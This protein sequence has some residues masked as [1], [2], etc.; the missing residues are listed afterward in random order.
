MQAGGGGAAPTGQGPRPP[1]AAS[2]DG[3][4]RPAGAGPGMGGG[5]RG[6]GIDE[7]VERFPDI[8][9]ADLKL[10]DTIAVVSSTKTADTVHIAAIKFL[11]GVEPFLKMA[12]MA[13]AAAGG[14][15]RGGQG[16][17]GSFTIPGLDGFGGP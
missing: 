7:M 14:Q 1:G 17:S 6:G 16:V 11:S 3:Q 12:Q 5:Q 8:K 2:Q 9:V 10:G 15:Q 13:Q 4:A